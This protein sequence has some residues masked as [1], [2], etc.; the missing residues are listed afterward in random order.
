LGK[1][2]I[3]IRHRPKRNI[4]TKGKEQTKMNRTQIKE[5]LKKQ[6]NTLFKSMDFVANNFLDNEKTGKK[7][8]RV[9]FNIYQGLGLAWEFLGLQCEHWDG[10]KK[11]KDNK[12][13]C[14]ICGKVKGVD[15]FYILLSKKGLK[16]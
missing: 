14:K 11:T 1:G 16:K 15:D 3:L 8:F 4:Q 12:E 2:T 10:Y 9:F 5:Q 7:E 6:L 13:V